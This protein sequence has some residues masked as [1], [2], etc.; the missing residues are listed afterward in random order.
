MNKYLIE[1]YM[2]MFNS[3]RPFGKNRVYWEFLCLT[4]DGEDYV[5]WLI[6]KMRNE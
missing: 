6:E 5:K 3:C 4:A 1:L 2:F